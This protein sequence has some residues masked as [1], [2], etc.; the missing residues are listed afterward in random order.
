MAR[1]PVT[2]LDD[3]ALGEAL[4][5]L[6]LTLKL[7]E[8]RRVAEL[9]GRDP[10]ETELTLFDTMWSEHCSYKSSRAV[11]KAHLPTDAGN[12]ILGPGEDAGIVRFAE[13]DGVRYGLVVGHESHNHPSQVMPVEGAATGIGG[14]VRDVYC[15]GAD[16]IATLDPLRFGNPDGKHAE[17]SREI[18]REVME[19]IALYGNALGVPNLGGDIVFDDCY[20]DNCLVNVVAVGLVREDHVVRSR[21]PAQARE[22]EYDIILVGK[23]TDWSG[24]G[25]A[26]FAS[27][28]LD[29]AAATENKGSVQVPDPFLKRVLVLANHAALQ[30]ARDQK[31]V[32][33]FKDLGAGGIAC[34]TS[35][36]ADAGG[37]GVELDLAL[38]N[39]AEDDLPPRV[40]ACSETQERFA[41]A[42]PARLT[43]RFLAVYNDT[44]E[45]GAMY[46]GARACRIGKVL[47][48]A[49]GEA[50]RYVLRHGDEVLVDAPVQTI[51]TGV[52]YDR[53]AKPASRSHSPEG[54]DTAGRDP[55]EDLVALFGSP[56]LCSRRSL[57]QHYDSE[58]KGNTVLRPGEA[59]AGVIAP[60]PGAAVGVA[61]SVDGNPRISRTDPYLGG[62][63]AVVESVR[64]VVCA[65]AV[66]LAVTDCL[67]YGNPEVPEVFHD[68]VEG[69]RGIGD[70]CRGLGRL[71]APEEPLPVVSG[72]VSFYN[73]SATGGAIAP[74]PIVCCLGLVADVSRARSLTL[75]S[76]GDALY[77][78]GA[79]VPGMG[80]S[81]YAQYVDPT[82]RGPVPPPD[83]AAL[84]AELRLVL[85][86]FHRGWAVAAHDVS[87]GGT[88]A[89]V[90]EMA[91]GPESHGSRGMALDLPADDTDA[92]FGEAGAFL[93]EIPEAARAEFEAAATRHGATVARIGTVVDD[94]VVRVGSREV[95]LRALA[96]ARER[97]L[98]RLLSR[99]G[100]AA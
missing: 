82:W 6:S 4:R 43:S 47:V 91:L 90:T 94:P 55:L 93:L 98:P 19:G 88:L 31:V 30:L 35:E 84:R 27:A 61:M 17:R 2:N 69:V 81:L 64:N 65:G 80:G 33:G 70:A 95:P 62:A 68:F 41:L 32:I 89:A 7:D 3:A 9:L 38:A 86:A 45:L 63:M 87:E 24:M 58:V 72:N 92:L 5:T 53:P 12:V 26:A 44:Y 11:L 56:H 48:P 73:Q 16:V 77:R 71:D 29:H 59:D 100:G 66:P 36:L 22:E 60:I 34:V 15:M 76:A 51:T 83:Y 40:A 54:L 13:V 28:D 25:G 18:A 78:V 97:T 85:E 99:T 10:T 52:A 23:P 79:F 96:D 75:K 1:V 37:V 46:E 67:N 39:L 21:V 57:F 20:D 50:P 14:V 42:V 74:S 49:D 8:A